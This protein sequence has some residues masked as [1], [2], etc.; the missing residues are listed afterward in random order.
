MRYIEYDQISEYIRERHKESG[1]TVVEFAKTLGVA[2]ENAFR[3]MNGS[4]RPCSRVLKLLE[5]EV[6][7]RVPA[8][9]R[10]RKP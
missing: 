5:A 2:R 9:S 4:L 8:K 10:K 7:F 3:Y 1:L 6:L